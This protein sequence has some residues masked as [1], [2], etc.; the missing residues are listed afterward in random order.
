MRFGYNSG[1]ECSLRSLAMSLL[2][3][4]GRST[5]VPP[6]RHGLAKVLLSPRFT[7]L[8][9]PGVLLVLGAVYHFTTARTHQETEK[10]LRDELRILREEKEGMESRLKALEAEVGELRKRGE[11]KSASKA[12]AAPALDELLT[13][14]PTKFPAGD[15]HLKEP[16]FEDVSFQAA[17]GV[18]LHGWYVK[19]SAPQA[20]I[21]YCHGNGGNVSYDSELLRCLHDRLGVSVLDFDY[22]GYG[23][24]EG[25]PTV[26]GVLL[27]AR[28]ARELLARKEGLNNDQVVLMGRSLGGGIVV[29][30]AKEGARG[31]ILESTFTSLRDT[32]GYHYPAPLVS[33][34]VPARLE[35]LTAIASYHG[36]LLISHGDA[37]ETIP[38]THGQK[39]FAAAAGRKTFVTISGGNHNGPQSAEYYEALGNFLQSL[40]HVSP[41]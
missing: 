25:T 34:F 22:R 15:W 37:D 1:M 30:L 23:K 27:D 2:E 4:R 13:F 14:F 16:T 35:S 26:A 12:P 28:A 20:A 40:P 10:G 6:E 31:L 21:L 18:K 33:L 36:P 11:G 32:A 39:L 9:L 7:G 5:S 3:E 29:D 41:H 38:F 24:S 17:D 19:H 8:L